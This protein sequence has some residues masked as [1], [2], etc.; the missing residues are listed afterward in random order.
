MT[1]ATEDC[2]F[3]LILIK[4]NHMSNM[5]TILNSID[6]GP[7]V[8]IKNNESHGAGGVAQWECGSVCL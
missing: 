2:L 7:Q 6:V 4:S 3:Y 1:T 8:H 5:T